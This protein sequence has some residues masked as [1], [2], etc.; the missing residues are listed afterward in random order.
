MRIFIRVDA[1][2][3]IGTGH[4]YR[5]LNLADALR[6]K[7]CQSLFAINSADL[8]LQ[9]KISKRGHIAVNLG[10]NYI[11]F[12]NSIGP[13]S[14]EQQLLDVKNCYELIE[15]YQPD[16][17]IVDHYNLDYNW[18][19][20]LKPIVKKILVIDDLANRKHDCSFLLDQTP[21]RIASDYK[22]LVEVDTQLLIGPQYTIL[23]PDF[24]NF[25]NRNIEKPP[26]SN[27]ILVGMGGL[28]SNNLIPKILTY[29]E[30]K[31]ELS[32]YGI[33]IV[34]SSMAPQ[35][36]FLEKIARSSSLRI[37]L[38]VETE[39]FAQVLAMS[40][41]AISAGGLMSLELA[42]LGVPAIILPLNE[43][44]GKVSSNLSGE[45]DFFIARNWASNFESTLNSGIDFLLKIQTANK[46]RRIHPK[47][48]GLGTLRLV[49][50]LINDT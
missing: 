6:Q 13:A 34:I 32:L 39:N 45:V 40:D 21:V 10:S 36:K 28:D 16:L 22:N 46:K 2:K 37:R 31:T 24:N 33:N 8:D 14:I 41:F 17:L 47:I 35:I 5:C 44:Q 42:C 15:K 26:S 43:I 3:D 50:F 1:S 7:G 23:N 4:L 20:M 49:D 38:N 11:T 27:N 18:E 19:R 9:A 29:L 12:T 25:R 30:R 48:D